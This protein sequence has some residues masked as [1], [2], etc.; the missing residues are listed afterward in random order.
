MGE[1]TAFDELKNQLKLGVFS[2]YKAQFVL[3]DL[4]SVLIF[5]NIR[6]MFI[7]VAEKELNGQKLKGQINRNIAITIVKKIG[8]ICCFQSIK[9]Y[10]L[11]LRLT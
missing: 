5:Y 9:E 4:W 10:M 8:L 11:K 3:Q 6:S 2:G 7:H 1:E